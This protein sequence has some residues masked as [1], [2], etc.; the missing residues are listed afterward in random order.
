MSGHNMDELDALL[1]E[2]EEAV[3]PT[4]SSTNNNNYNSNG[5]NYNNKTYSHSNNN[6][7]K[8][9]NS[10]SSSSSSSSGLSDYR[11]RTPPS[12]NNQY[13][14]SSS[15]TSTSSYSKSYTSSRGVN[16]LGVYNNNDKQVSYKENTPP[17][18]PPG[19]GDGFDSPTPRGYKGHA[20]SFDN[21]S[22]TDLDDL[23][24]MTEQLSTNDNTNSKK[25]NNKYTSQRGVAKRRF[26]GGPIPENTL[27]RRDHEKQN[28]R[29][30]SSSGDS[31]VLLGGTNCVLGDE[32]SKFRRVVND[33]LLCLKCMCEVV[34][35]ENVAWSRDADYIFFRNFWPDAD[36][37]CEK[38]KP[39]EGFAAYCCQ[40]AWANAEEVKPID[41]FSCANGNLKWKTPIY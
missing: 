3:K 20:N 19:I 27:R 32:P 1:N 10:S 17:P 38:M 31:V 18:T 16:S 33:H 15:Y 6:N 37:L 13:K 34:R 30:Q 12:D 39:K 35:F 14:S 2:V 24:G 22:T 28:S 9:S 36:R 29:K 7:N 26:H 41:N 11:G 23:L 21:D 4:S 25:S 40:C 5:N 8:Y